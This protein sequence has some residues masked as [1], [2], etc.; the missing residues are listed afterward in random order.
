MGVGSC[1]SP[2]PS[3]APCPKLQ[4]ALGCPV[5]EGS[6][7]AGVSPGLV[8]LQPGLWS[9]PCTWEGFVPKVTCVLALCSGTT[10]ASLTPYPVTTACL[11]VLQ[12]P[13]PCSWP[14]P[15]FC[16]VT[17][18]VTPGVPIT[19]VP[20]APQET[21]GGDM[22]YPGVT[23]KEHGRSVFIKCQ[24]AYLCEILS[25]LKDQGLF[26]VFGGTQTS[27]CKMGC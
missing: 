19:I 11:C 20:I 25:Q 24:S 16:P 6:S 10:P 8:T 1:P 17:C 2:Q 14:P 5:L 27:H 18:S 15:S 3:A 7:V 23:L 26:R 13:C 9:W 22:R 4:A 12:T 21:V